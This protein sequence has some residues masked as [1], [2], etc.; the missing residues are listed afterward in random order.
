MGWRYKQW[1]DYGGPLVTLRSLDFILNVLGNHRSFK[2]EEVTFSDFILKDISGCYIEN[3]GLKLGMGV[4]KS[5]KQEDALENLAKVCERNVSALGNL[6]ADMRRSIKIQD[7]FQRKK[8]FLGLVG[9]ECDRIWVRNV[10][11]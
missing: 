10:E 1:L 5:R 6:L 4:W 11:S 8:D 7:T 9:E 2:A 3:I